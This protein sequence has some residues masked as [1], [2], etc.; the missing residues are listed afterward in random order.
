MFLFVFS[1]LQQQQH[2]QQQQQQTIQHPHSMLNAPQ[3]LPQQLQHVSAGQQR[4]LFI[5]KKK[6]FITFSFIPILNLSLCLYF[7]CN[8]FVLFRITFGCVYLF[9]FIRFYVWQLFN[10][11]FC[12]FRNFCMVSYTICPFIVR[13]YAINV[14]AQS[15]TWKYNSEFQFEYIVFSHFGHFSLHTTQIHFIMHWAYKC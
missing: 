8:F 14:Q 9:M 12:W 4:C 15:Y 11:F 5:Q 6:N 2:Q 1:S 3:H 13:Y 10:A 7:V